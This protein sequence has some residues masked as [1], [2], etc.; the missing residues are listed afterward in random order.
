[1][2]MR[3]GSW[4]NSRQNSL[5]T[6]RASRSI[7]TDTRTRCRSRVV[8]RSSAA[9]R[10]TKRDLNGPGHRLQFTNKERGARYDTSNWDVLRSEW[11]VFHDLCD[12]RRP[13]WLVVALGRGGGGI[14]RARRALR[15]AQR[16]GAVWDNLHDLDGCGPWLHHVG[17]DG[18]FS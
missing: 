9:F 18:V 5:A 7:S 14:A 6:F 16:D 10:S 1:M 13:L 2:N 8:W 3:C 4:S 17:G 15:T 12:G 11:I